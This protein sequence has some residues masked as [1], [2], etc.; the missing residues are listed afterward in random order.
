MKNQKEQDAAKIN[1][2]PGSKQSISAMYSPSKRTM[3]VNR[4][5]QKS[6]VKDKSQKSF[7]SNVDGASPKINN[8]SSKTIENEA[9]NGKQ[10]QKSEKP[11]KGR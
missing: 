9:N 2:N 5:S 7:K 8:S 3:S 6:L 11:E 4:R 1:L 10:S